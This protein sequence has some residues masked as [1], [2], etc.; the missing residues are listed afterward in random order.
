M[1]IK[2]TLLFFFLFIRTVIWAQFDPAGGEVGSR[3]IDRFD[4]NIVGWATKCEVQRGWMQINDTTLGK[5]SVGRNDDVLGS[6]NGKVLSLGDGGV[7][8]LEFETPIVNYPGADFAIFEN[9]F[10]VGLSY[11]LELAFVEVSYDGL[12]FLRFPAESLSDTQNQVGNF[13]FLEPRELKNLAGKHQAPYGTL[14]DLDEVGLDT[15]KFVRIIDVVGSIDPEFGSRDSKGRI[16]N[17]PFPT[18]F[19]SGGFDL[20]AVAVVRESFGSNYAINQEFKVYPS[21]ASINQD[22]YIKTSNLS[23]WELQS[24]D[25]KTIKSGIENTFNIQQSGVYILVGY[26]E[27][28]K[29]TQKICVH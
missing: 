9:G 2:L 27:G 24:M 29:F 16:I 1:P 17:D 23:H 11:F 5:A 13:D 25:G 12:N 8:T 14:F 7:V 3:S 18:P 15:V 10:Q 4:A 6:A 20:D 19:E 28:S 26:L 21:L 22:I